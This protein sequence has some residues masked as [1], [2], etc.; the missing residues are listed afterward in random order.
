MKSHSTIK[1]V[2]RKANVSVAT[3]SRVLNGLTGYTP[4]TE[5]RV[6][7]AI[8]VLNY[9]CNAVA[10]NL[11]TQ[12]TNI[13]A[14]LIPQVETTFYVKILNGIER[15]AQESGY[16]IIICPVG[17]S[18]RQTKEYIKMLA[19]RRVDGIIGCSLPP[20]EEIDMLM[21]RCGIPC[22]LV[23]T[24][25]TRY[26]IPFVRVDDRKASYA[27]TSYLIEK[28]HKKIALLAGT[29]DDEVAGKLRFQGFLS[30]LSNHGLSLD[31]ELVQYT[32][33]SFETGLQAARHLLK[34]G[35]EFTGIVACCDDVAVAAISAAHEAGVSV[36]ERFSVI[37][38]DNTR[39][40][41]MSIPPLTTVA[42]PL[43]SMGEQVFE[44]LLLEIETGEKANS[45]VLPYQI[46]ERNSVRAIQ[47]EQK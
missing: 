20:K 42:Q 41:E 1:D 39:T 33:F 11:K 13:V 15:A 23:S 2:A 47:T 18:G 32:D 8:K 36:P 4:T 37:G 38:Y 9:Q 45:R 6:R 29:K 43:Q 21:E 7:D 22:A 5:K 16:N 19:R 17:T 34:A 27:A 26:S 10:K 3:V 31:E 40:A 24:L 14:V 35:K 46:I 44:M 25:S 28:G 12:K 30:A